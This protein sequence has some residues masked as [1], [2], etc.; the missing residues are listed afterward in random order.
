MNNTYKF[1]HHAIKIPTLTPADRILEAAK[2]LESAIEQQPK[3]APLDELTAI[4][5]LREVLLGE[6]TQPLPPNSVQRRKAAQSTAAQEQPC[7]PQPAVHARTPTA[8]PAVT[9]THTDQPPTAS[10]DDNEPNYVSNDES[11]EP[12]N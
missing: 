8:V 12:D 10:P 7:E 2:Q 1:K 6:K 3:N 4:Q 5:L 9:T 11:V